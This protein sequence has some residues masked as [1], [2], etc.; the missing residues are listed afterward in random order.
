MTFYAQLDSVGDDFVVADCGRVYVFVCFDDYT[1][2]SRAPVELTTGG[3][4]TSRGAWVSRRL[5]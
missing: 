2:S 3:R 1:H 5:L 4:W